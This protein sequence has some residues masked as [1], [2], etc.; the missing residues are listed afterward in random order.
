MNYIIVFRAIL[1]P[2]KPIV[3]TVTAVPSFVNNF[4]R[5]INR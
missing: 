3:V 1:L 2:V 5:S 4:K